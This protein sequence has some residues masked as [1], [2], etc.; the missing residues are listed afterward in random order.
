MLTEMYMKENGKMIK[1]MGMGSMFTWMGLY[2][3][4]SL[5]NL[6]IVD[7]GFVGDTV[8]LG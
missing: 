8:Y 5:V 3:I 6:F 7:Y 2:I 4:K 1:H